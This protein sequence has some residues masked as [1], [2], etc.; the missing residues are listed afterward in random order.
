MIIRKAEEK[1]IPRILVMNEY[2]G[3]NVTVG[4]DV[5]MTISSGNTSAYIFRVILEIH[6]KQWFCGTIAT[7]LEG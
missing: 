3:I 2:A 1:D 5:Q 7:D 6:C 4:I